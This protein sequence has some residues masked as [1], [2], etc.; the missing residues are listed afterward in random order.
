MVRSRTTPLP[1]TV[2]VRGR[3]TVGASMTTETDPAA[4]ATATRNTVAGSDN[5]GSVGTSAALRRTGLAQPVRP[6]PEPSRSATAR[7][8]AALLKPCLRCGTPGPASYCDG[9]QPARAPERRRGRPARPMKWRNYS[10]RV[11]KVQP[12]CTRCGQPGNSTPGG[13]LTTDHVESE[14][15]GGPP[16]PGPEGIEV[17]CRRCHGIKTAQDRRRRTVTGSGTGGGTPDP[18]GVTSRGGRPG[19]HYTP[20]VGDWL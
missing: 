7:A 2:R 10:K 11:R 14:A 4:A 18:K 9:C 20:G 3:T 13:S 19:P 15:D 6:Q 12:W 16:M 8:P 1:P 17:L 5:E